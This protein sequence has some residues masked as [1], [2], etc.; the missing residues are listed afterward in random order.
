[1]T[2]AQ[3]IQLLENQIT[4]EYEKYDGK[5]PEYLDG[6]EHEK[7]EEIYSINSEASDDKYYG[8]MERNY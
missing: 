4:R 3:K 8:R 6:W 5:L 1:M 7:I 2:S